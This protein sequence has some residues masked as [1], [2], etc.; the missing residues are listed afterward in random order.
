MWD[1]LIKGGLVVD[2][3]NSPG[4][5]ADVALKDGKIAAMG[6]DLQG[7]AAQ[8]IDATGLIV[9]PGF[10]DMHSHADR[11]IIANPLCES[12]LR[13]G[14]TFVL[15]GQCGGSTAPLTVASREQ[16]QQ[17]RPDID[18]L[19]LDEFFQRLDKETIGVNIAMQVGQ[20]TIRGAVMGAADRPATP[21][22]LE[23]QKALLLQ[24]MQDGSF[25]LTT[26]RRYMPGCLAQVEEIIELNKVI[27]PFDGLHSSHIANQDKEV[28]D[29]LQELISIGRESGSRVQLVHQ[30][31][32]GKPSWGKAKECLEMME[33]ARAEGIDILSDLY[34]HPYTQIIAIPGVIRE[35]LGGRVVPEQWATEEGR[36]KLIADLRQGLA[37]KAERA[38]SVQHNA[39]LWCLNTKEYEWLDLAEGAAK[40]GT[41]LATYMVNLLHLN[42][43]QVKTA[44]IMGDEDI[45]AIL[46]HP[47]S[48]LGT[49]S[50][51]VDGQ[52]INPL[53]AHPRNY[54]TYPYTLKRYVYDEKLLSL[55]TCIYKMSG[56]VAHRL[57][58]KDRGLLREGYWADLV[59]FDPQTI[60][61]TAS[62]SEPNNY[63]TGII[64]VFVNGQWAVKESAGTGVRA[65]MTIRNP[66]CQA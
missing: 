27:V 11:T 12:A 57:N 52:N 13:Q 10:M 56:M 26:G 46:K 54:E 15:A 28:F 42:D 7:E 36:H 34:V 41:D 18:W 25:G 20:G 48:M 24:A 4:I 5:K 62:V 53:E 8:V 1:F 40:M 38:M 59:V 49:D 55:E 30:K 45:N 50:Y 21:E 29:S 60:A 37:A 9:T 58:L 33:A 61:P 6:R 32:C 31:V 43:G 16:M 22:E 64:H 47:F 14:I 39:V 35:F 17:R 65:G 66:K 63:P 51:V 3:S 23:Q 2:G 19:T 44:G